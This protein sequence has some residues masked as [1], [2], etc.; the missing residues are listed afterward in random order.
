MC[1]NEVKENTTFEFEGNTFSI[2]EEVF[3]GMHFSASELDGKS[4]GQKMKESQRLMG[5]AYN[6]YGLWCTPSDSRHWEHVIPMMQQF[7]EID[8]NLQHIN[9][10]LGRPLPEVLKN[11]KGL[12]APRMYVFNTCPKT[13]WEIEGWHRNPKTGRPVDKDDHLIAGIK[14]L[15]GRPRLYSG[16]WWASEENHD[17][18]TKMPAHSEHTGY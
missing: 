9:T 7:F 2:Y 15:A 11:N 3:T 18:N 16:D 6:A 10:R 12:G 17:E 8:H 4:Y 5:E 1:G 14:F 13:R